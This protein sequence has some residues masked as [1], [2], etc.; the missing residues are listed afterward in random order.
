MADGLWLQHVQPGLVTWPLGPSFRKPEH[1]LS[2][3]GPKLLVPNQTYVL[4]RRFSAKEDERRIIAA[5][6]LEGTLDAAQLG[7]ENHVN[8][9]HR[10][11]GSMTG[12]EARGLAALLN[13]SLVDAYFRI[14]SGN[15]QVSATELRG[16]P[17]PSSS[18]LSTIAA[19]VERGHEPDRAVSEGPRHPL[20]RTPSPC[21]PPARAAW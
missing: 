12:A 1:I 10:P 14:S 7:L 17:L 13:S 6:Y 20:T 9:V 2:A 15:T 4:M 8:F 11:G 18:A 21:R 5:P 16:L 19:L 3:A